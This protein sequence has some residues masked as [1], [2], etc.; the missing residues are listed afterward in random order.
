MGARGRVGVRFFERKGRQDGREGSDDALDFEVPALVGRDRLDPELLCQAGGHRPRL[1]PVHEKVELDVGRTRPGLE[2]DDDGPSCSGRL[3]ERRDLVRV[4][5][6]ALLAEGVEH[7][8]VGRV[9]QR[10][11]RRD[12]VEQEREPGRLEHEEEAALCKRAEAED[13]P[14][15]IGLLV[16]VAESTAGQKEGG[17]SVLGTG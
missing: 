17:G 14:A 9:G 2:L 1:G 10:C 7:G 13:R 8:K 5:G 4:D 15:L 6:P 12:A 16:A 3:G 11:R